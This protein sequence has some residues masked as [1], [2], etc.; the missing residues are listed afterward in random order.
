MLL[1]H[2]AA[3]ASFAQ[4]HRTP[5]PHAKVKSVNPLNPKLDKKEDDGFSVILKPAIR[6]SFLFTIYQK[7]KP[8]HNVQLNPATRQAEGFANREAAFRAANWMI[9]AYRK[10]GVFPDLIPPNIASKLNLDEK[11]AAW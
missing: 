11:Q 8:V 2:A 6:R 10:D 1:L 5:N 4:Q 9:A 7:G 3:L